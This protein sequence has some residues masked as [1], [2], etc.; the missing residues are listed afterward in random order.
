MQETVFTVENNIDLATFQPYHN[1]NKAYINCI[2][3]KH[4]PS[5][6]TAGKGDACFRSFGEWST[7][8]LFQ[9]IKMHA[10][11]NLVVRILW[12]EKQDGPLLVMHQENLISS[13]IQR[14]RVPHILHTEG[15]AV[16]LWVLYIFCRQHYLSR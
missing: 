3:H 2:Q 1:T 9:S 16:V 6:S 11:A 15:C 5:P 8:A 14:L 7:P 13:S 12:W 4:C 10:K